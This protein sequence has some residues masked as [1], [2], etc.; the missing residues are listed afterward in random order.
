MNV[1]WLVNAQRNFKEKKALFEELIEEDLGMST[2]VK[3][4]E[5]Y[6]RAIELMPGGHSNLRISVGVKPLFIERGDGAR[7]WDVD[8]NEYIDYMIAAG[9]GILGQSE[10]PYIQA[11]KDQ[12]DTLYYL[13]TGAAQSPM[14]IEL[15]EKFVQ[16]VPCAEKVRFC[17]SGT[18]AVQ[19]AIRLAR[20]YTKRTYFI[21]F[22]GHYHG[23]LDNVIG[24]MVD[25]TATE[26]PYAVESDNDPLHTEGR[27]PWAMKESFKI[28]WNDIEILERVLEKYGGEVAMI[29]MEPILCL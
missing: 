13:I 11:L 22:E 24:G 8:G 17:L 26:R 4:R 28:P 10:E 20:A 18:E 2:N 1:H 23:W 29:H 3:N 15:A 7:L 16:Y 5:L 6:E 27:S 19:L 9:P 12:L 21:R 25:D 14:E